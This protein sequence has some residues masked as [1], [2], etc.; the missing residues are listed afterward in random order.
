M[1]Q[2]RRAGNHSQ[3]VRSVDL[4]PRMEGYSLNSRHC[5]SQVVQNPRRLDQATEKD[6]GERRITKNK[7]TARRQAKAVAGEN[8]G[9]GGDKQLSP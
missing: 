2:N 1:L 8:R 5:K 3:C 6:T 9:V 4:L 7:Q